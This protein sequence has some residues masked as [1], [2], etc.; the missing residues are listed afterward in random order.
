MRRGREVAEPFT[1]AVARLQRTR[2]LSPPA[3]S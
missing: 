2:L 1:A 3:G